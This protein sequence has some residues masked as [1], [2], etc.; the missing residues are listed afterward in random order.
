VLSITGKG[1]TRMRDIEGL[2]SLAGL[3]E[4]HLDGNAIRAIEC[5]DGLAGLEVL[6]LDN[7]HIERIA[8]LDGLARLRRLS[9]AG[10]RIDRIEGLD[11]L[12][13]LQ[14]LDLS[15][16][17]IIRKVDIKALRVTL[18]ALQS[19]DL[20]GNPLVSDEP[21]QH[22]SQWFIGTAVRGELELG[23]SRPKKTLGKQLRAHVCDKDGALPATFIVPMPAE[24][25]GKTF[26]VKVT[27]LAS[28]MAEL[29]QHAFY[30]I[31][32]DIAGEYY[33]Y[34]RELYHEYLVFPQTEHFGY[35]GT[36]LATARHEYDVRVV[37]SKNWE[38]SM[39]DAYYHM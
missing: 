14:E 32:M 21:G 37:D 18:P 8:G 17:Y 5:L 31:L 13:S 34:E 35:Y 19:M 10:N 15:R 2:G 9:L 7:N 22:A 30:Y 11:A 38:A 1:I 3:K 12:G 20:E 4:L 36:D 33:I 25:A 26:D 28:N 16:N 27:V 23:S 24:N 39:R 29:D 6:S